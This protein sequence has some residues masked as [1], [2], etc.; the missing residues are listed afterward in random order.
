MGQRAK[1]EAERAKRDAAK[2]KPV[3]LKQLQ[4]KLHRQERARDTTVE[5]AEAAQAELDKFAKS[6]ASAEEK[7]LE[8][9]RKAADAAE[10]LAKAEAEFERCALGSG[11]AHDDARPKSPLSMQCRTMLLC[12]K[13]SRTS[14]TS[15]GRDD[16][17]RG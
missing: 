14:L 6:L 17:R 16:A 1:L 10:A 9:Q 12:N 11:E 15:F 4:A 8:A 5:A 2:P 7:Q 3:H 13:P